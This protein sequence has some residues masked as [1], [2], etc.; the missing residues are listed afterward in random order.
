MADA[1]GLHAGKRG[2]GTRLVRAEDALDPGPARSLGHAEDAADATHAAV[3]RQLAARRML[4]EP[5]TR[6]LTRRG[7]QRERDRDVEA[8]ALLLQLGGGEVDGRLV[9]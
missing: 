2:F 6:N 1:H 4:G 9:A 5:F 8:G 3:E 7:E